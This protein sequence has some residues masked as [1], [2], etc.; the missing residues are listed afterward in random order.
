M[1]SVGFLSCS[2]R[3]T[4]PTGIDFQGEGEIGQNTLPTF[5][6][7]GADEKP[8][9]NGRTQLDSALFL[10]LLQTD[11]ISRAHYGSNALMWGG[12]APS[13]DDNMYWFTHF[14]LK[15]QSMILLHGH[16]DSCPKVMP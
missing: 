10:L 11:T 15:T 8:F 1:F 6:A 9:F 7:S 2:W 13:L 5:F 16:F 14:K 4:Q 3:V 12:V